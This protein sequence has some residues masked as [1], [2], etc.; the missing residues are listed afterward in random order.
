MMMD[1]AAVINVARTFTAAEIPFWLD[2]G[3]GVDALIGRQS[4]AH[5]DLDLIV[6]AVRVP[7]V[8]RA[9]SALGYDL[10]IDDTPTRIV[11]KGGDARQIDIHLL[12]LD[13]EGG[14]FQP[15]PDGSVWRCPPAWLTGCGL[16]AGQAVPCLSADGQLAAHTG[17]ALTDKDRH[18]LDLLQSHM[19]SKR[20]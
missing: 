18:D 8:S 5:E 4:R 6:P 3:W 7:A 11:F 15:L 12:V 9:L 20:G 17:Y 19:G 10:A 1:A 2:G 16:V 14:G 13:D